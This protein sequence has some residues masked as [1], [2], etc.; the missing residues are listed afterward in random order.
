MAIYWDYDPVLR[1][2]RGDVL[3]A[4]EPVLHVGPFGKRLDQIV[5]PFSAAIDAHMGNVAAYAKHSFWP[6]TIR[7]EVRNVLQRILLH[8]VRYRHGGALLSSSADG[9]DLT[10]KFSVNY[11][12]LTVAI[13]NHLVAAVRRR[14]A[15]DTI[16]AENPIIPTTFGRYQQL[17]HLEKDTAR[18]ISGCVHS[19][20]SLARVDGLVWLSEQLTVNGFGVEIRTDGDPAN[21]V[22]CGDA[23]ASEEAMELR[24]PAQFGMRHRSMMRFCYA[25]PGSLGFV[26]S[27]DGPVRAML[28]ENDR[29]LLWEDIRL[30]DE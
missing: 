7:R 19:I 17:D 9:S 28:R 15:W 1:S 11:D 29:L 27:Q 5:Q 22:A 12:R 30:R 24:D 2:I 3:L 21:V 23:E 4:P 13:L 20:A 8:V 6:A 26:V 16:L 25:H 18:E 10:P 14:D